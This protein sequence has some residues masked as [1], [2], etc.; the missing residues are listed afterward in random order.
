MDGDVAPLAEYAALCRATGAA[1]IVDEAHAVGVYG[2]ARQ[3]AASRQPGVDPNGVFVSINTAGKA[4]GVSGAF[5]AGPAWAIEYLVQRARPFIFS[6][7]PPPAHRRRARRE[8]GRHR[9]RAGAA[10]TSGCSASRCLRDA[11][12]TNGIAVSGRRR[13]RSSRSSSATTS[14]RWPSPTRCRREGFDVRAIRPP[15]VPAGTARLRISVNAKLDDDV[16]DRFASLA[17]RL[18]R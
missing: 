9:Q 15:S 5:V 1:L 17:R 12:T 8:P 18:R 7:A 6:T 13:R 4:L 16:I 11:L 3:R 10:R 14:A 2:D